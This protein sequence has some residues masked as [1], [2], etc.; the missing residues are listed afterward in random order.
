MKRFFYFFTFIFS[1]TAIF[2]QTFWTETFGTGCNQAQLANGLNAGGNGAWV[3]TNGTSPNQGFANTWYISAEENGNPVGS[4]GTGCGTNRTLH[5]AN[6]PGSPL[7]FICPTGDCGAAYDAGLAGGQVSTD[8]RAESPT[9]NC[10]G[11]SNITLSFDYLY[12]GDPPN[13]MGEVWYFNGATWALLVGPPQTTCGD[14]T[15]AC[16]PVACGSSFNAQGVWGNLTTTLPVS[17]NNNAGVKIGFRWVNNDDGAGGDPS[18]AIDNIRLSSPTSFTPNF[19]ITSPLCAGQSATVTATANPATVALTGY[20]WSASPAG[21]VIA[22]PNSSSTGI[23]FPTSGVFS[24]TL[25]ASD[26]TGT[27]TTTQTV[28]VNPSPTVSIAASTTIVCSGSSAT[29]TANGATSYAWSPSTGLSSTTG[30]VVTASPTSTQNY[31]VIGT[32]GTCTNSAVITVST[33]PALAVTVS[34]NFTICP[35]GSTTLTANGATNYNWSGGTGLSSS[36]GASVV[37]SPSSNQTYL[38]VGSDPSTGCTGSVTCNVYIGP[39]I[40]VTVAPSSATYCVGAPGKTLVASGAATYFWQP[41]QGLNTTFGATVIATPTITTQYTVLG[42]TGS[43]TGIAFVTVTV[44]PK[45][46]LTITPTNTMICIGQAYTYTASGAGTNGTYTWAPAFT[47]SNINGYTNTA[48]PTVTTTYTISGQTQGGCLTNTAQVTLTV[49]PIPTQTISLTTNTNAIVTNSVCGSTNPVTLTI[50]NS[51]P[52]LGL[53]YDYTITPQNIGTPSPPVGN[54]QTSGP[55]T[56]QALPLIDPCQPSYLVTYTAQLSYNNIPGCK[57]KIDTV[58]LRVVNC[59]TPT[60]SFTTIIPNDTICTKACIALQNTSCGG[61]PQTIKWYTPG[62]QIDS[63]SQTYP[64]ICYN[65]PGNYTI[66]MSVTNPYGYDSIVK[67]NFIHVVDTPNTDALRDTCIRY[68]SSVQLYGIQASTYMWNSVG[69]NTPTGLS[70]YGCPNPI[71]NPTVTTT[72][73]LTG[74]NSKN[75]K[76]NDTLTVCVIQDCGEMFVP[77]AFSPNADGVNDILYVRGRCLK[78]FTFQIFNRWGEKVFETS[79]Q[80]S[81]WDGTYKDEPMNTAVF[82]YRLEGTTFDELPYRM[83]GNVTLIR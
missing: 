21:P 45:A 18:F 65:T 79:D 28:Q 76:Y 51:T 27:A 80:N 69:T 38:V 52:T 41:P 68:G 75:C 62:G 2:S 72:Y 73:V 46:S 83:K 19:T 8:K 11:K 34:G 57:S 15:A 50:N 54:I 64:I 53:S 40:T 23:T 82:V 74:Y 4:C 56:I 59:F 26:A 24:I 61:Q 16:A 14:I 55:T 71:A 25:L 36:T 5:V 66:S 9:I 39:P 7:A 44:A 49:V 35:G 3:V 77:N 33:Q 12:F 17:A 78:N 1:F 43:C 60:A 47:L 13:D 67:T 10:T 32:S 31:T 63:T 48:S 6:V 29:L 20:T 70:C 58:T 81:G 22:S 30:A 42:S 37:A